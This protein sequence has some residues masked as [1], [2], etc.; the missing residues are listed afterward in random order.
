[1]IQ[2]SLRSVHP[3]CAPDAP[4][5]T[6]PPISNILRW[7][8]KKS[9]GSNIGDSGN[10][11][12]GDKTRRWSNR[13]RVVGIGEMA[14]EA[15]RSLDRSSEGSEEVFPVRLMRLGNSPVKS[16]KCSGTEDFLG[17]KK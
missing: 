5:G 15:K 11:G 14:S 17:W 8:R 13:A 16:R 6:T 3:R 4:Y 2:N 12:D 9:Q 1:M 7:G 10:T